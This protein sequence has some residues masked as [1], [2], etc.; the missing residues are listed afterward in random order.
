M[1]IQEQRQGRMI[2]LEQTNNL[3]TKAEQ[4]DRKIRTAW[5]SAKQSFMKVAKLLNNMRESD[6][7]KYLKQRT[8]NNFPD[9]LKSV[10]GTDCSTSH[11]YELLA[12]YG[13]TTGENAIPEKKVEKMGIKKAYQLAR[14]PR[15]KRT[16]E[17]VKELTRVPFYKAR[18]IVQ[19]RINETLPEHERK[20]VTQ[21]FQ[22]NY[23]PETISLIEEIEEVGIYMEGV[24]D[25][26]VSV[27]L[28]DK[29]TYRVWALFAET[30]AEEL[31][32]AR[33]IKAT[34]E[35]RD[36]KAEVA[37]NEEEDEEEALEPPD[38]GEHRLAVLDQP[39]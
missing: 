6:L 5:R 23:S 3:V 30:Y 4:L 2:T 20:V 14:L 18:R 15:D 9:Y 38:P 10:I 36:G 25:G 39:F 33:K 13:L 8:Y 29:L 37:A 7:W 22:R 32:E 27:S 34:K 35:A 11:V 1:T 16:P 21:L 28:R 31:E 19:E 26:D 17:I 12:A 24:Q